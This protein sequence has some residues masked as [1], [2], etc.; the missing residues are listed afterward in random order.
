M[1][2]FMRRRVEDEGVGALRGYRTVNFP[3]GHFFFSTFV[4]NKKSPK[5]MK[6]KIAVI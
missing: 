3:A 6:K 2:L 5:R 1:I 4:P